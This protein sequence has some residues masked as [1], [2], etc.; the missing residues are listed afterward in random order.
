MKIQIVLGAIVLI[1]C[2]LASVTTPDAYADPANR[3]A[4]SKL[5]YPINL[6]GFGAPL[7]AVAK[8]V[9]DLATF[10]LRAA[11]AEWHDLLRFLRL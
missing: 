10:S 6:D 1:L 8:S 5:D 4:K 11:T 2:A 9:P 3:N 7:P